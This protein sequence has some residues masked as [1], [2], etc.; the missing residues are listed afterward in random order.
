VSDPLGRV[1]GE[2]GSAEDVAARERAAFGRL[3]A[4]AR[5]AVIFGSGSLG[6][7]ILAGARA[8]GVTVAAFA[9][10]NR[11]LWGT[12]V[13]GVPVL[14]PADALAR[15]GDR[16]Y[17]IVGVYNSSAPRRQLTALGCTRIV[18]YPAFFWEFHRTIPWA[19]GL[20]LPSRIVAAAPAIREGFARLADD[21]S[22]EEFA[23]QIAWRCTLD[24]DRL[25]PPDPG[26]DIYFPPDLVRLTGA[27][28][29]VD[30]GA[31]DGDSIRLF[32]DRT[33]RRFAHVY[34]CEPDAR[35]RQALAANLET[36]GPEA[37][38]RVTILP[39]AIGGRDGTVRFDTSG[40][41]GSH[42]TA[43]EASDAV[44]LRTLDTLLKDAA[45]TFIKMDIEGAEP[46]ALHGAT[47][48]LRRS[49][50]ILAVCAYHTCEHLWTLPAIISAAVPD[51]RISLRR[52]AEECWEM[53]YYAVPPERAIP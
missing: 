1:L 30:C 22:R 28:V 46:E 39:F 3:A 53:V 8:S 10:N 43:D 37:R 13:D 49:R 4:G 14:D 6:R 47:A 34:A 36:L 23:A 44:E 31:F 27:E 35:N 19:P 40:T 18:S 25:A 17:V 21:R 42:M 41:A 52:Y 16:V 48:T 7:I 24:Y 45:P 29:L 26:A 50:P 5:D 9:D 38:A 12:E 11:S 20:E 51:Y 32:T 33:S 2:L 15:F